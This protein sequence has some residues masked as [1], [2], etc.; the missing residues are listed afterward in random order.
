MRLDPKNPSASVCKLCVAVILAVQLHSHL[1]ES[2]YLNEQESKPR[3]QEQHESEEQQQQHLQ[4]QQ[5]M[6][7][8]LYLAKLLRNLQSRINSKIDYGIDAFRRRQQ[9]QQLLKE[10]L[11]NDSD[12]EVASSTDDNRDGEPLGFF[13]QV[14][15]VV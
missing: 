14:W 5:M 8:H 11:S 7:D 9:Q 4:K 12:Y 10:I 15:Q 13:W 2:M 6:A 3:P 1:A